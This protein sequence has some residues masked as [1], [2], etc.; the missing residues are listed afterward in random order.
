MIQLQTLHRH[1][2]VEIDGF[3]LNSNIH[4][5]QMD[6]SNAKVTENAGLV[7]DF[8][9]SSEHCFANDYSDIIKKLLLLN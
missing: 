6:I 9:A 5:I 2:H 8:N 4:L 3:E 7:S 1:A